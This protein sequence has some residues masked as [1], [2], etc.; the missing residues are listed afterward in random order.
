M[1]KNLYCVLDVVAKQVVSGI[2]QES[3]DA[4]A[5]RA[6]YDALRQPESLLG[7]HPA[8]FVLLYI[9]GLDTTDGT[10]LFGETTTVATG[11]GWLEAQ[12]GN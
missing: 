4:P 12:K 1:V 5:I 6:F 8:D 7:Q 11:T 10:M 3:N 9:G 2:I